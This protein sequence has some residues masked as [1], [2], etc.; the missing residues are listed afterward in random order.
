MFGDV[1]TQEARDLGT[2]GSQ[3]LL[4][5]GV[6]ALTTAVI[7]L[8][9]L[10]RADTKEIQ[11]RHDA[12]LKEQQTKHDAEKREQR[13]AYTEALSE[14]TKAVQAVHEEAKAHAAECRANFA[15]VINALRDR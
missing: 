7:F 5:V 13:E 10:W 3:A 2:M 9:R 12:V 4:G 15:T 8:F 6:L 14:I 1:I 11:T